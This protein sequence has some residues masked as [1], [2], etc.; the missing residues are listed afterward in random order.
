MVSPANRAC[1]WSSSGPHQTHARDRAVCGVMWVIVVNPIMGCSGSG[2][3]LWWGW[4]RPVM[5]ANLGIRWSTSW[6]VVGLR[7]SLRWLRMS[8]R[9]RSR[10]CTARGSVARVVCCDGV[11]EGGQAVC[12]VLVLVRRDLFSDHR[13]ERWGQGGAGLLRTLPPPEQHAGRHAGAMN[14][15]SGA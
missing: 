2:V 11:L 4:S 12:P 3:L 5:A 9:L 15:A 8:A 7:R 14:V 1:T 6:A 13:G 10:S